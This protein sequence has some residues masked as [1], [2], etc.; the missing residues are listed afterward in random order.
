MIIIFHAELG[1]HTTPQSSN[2]TSPTPS[3]EGA[4]QLSLDE[5]EAAYLTG[6]IVGISNLGNTCY[7]NSMIQCLSHT[8]EM[9]NIF[10][11]RD[12]PRGSVCAGTLSVCLSVC[13]SVVILFIYSLSIYLCFLQNTK[14]LCA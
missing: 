7:M 10:L 14:G 11:S 2:T 8:L 13:L 9:T 1:G 3:P 12:F 5:V 4:T 6:G